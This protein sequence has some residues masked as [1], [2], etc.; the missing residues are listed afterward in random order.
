MSK[1]KIMPKTVSSRDIQ[2]SYK[3]I[4]EEAMSFHEPI[5]VMKNNQPQVAIVSID[6]L[7][8]LKNNTLVHLNS[9]EDLLDNEN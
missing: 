7:D 9:L 8:D 5:V 1:N 3:A 6:Y 4:F 2:T